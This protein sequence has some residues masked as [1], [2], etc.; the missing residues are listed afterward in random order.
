MLWD[1]GCCNLDSK[2]LRYV[3]LCICQRKLDL[4]I[5]AGDLYVLE[6]YTYDYSYLRGPSFV[7][8]DLLKLIALSKK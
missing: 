8:V 7:F 4:T 3:I 2:R 5:F 1:K 6:P